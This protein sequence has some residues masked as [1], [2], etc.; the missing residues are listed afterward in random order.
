[1]ARYVKEK[2]VE[3]CFHSCQFF[4]TSGHIMECT[5]PDFEK[6]DWEKKL[7]INQ[8]NS[9]G[10]VPDKCPLRKGATEIVMRIKL[11]DNA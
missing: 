4:S 11:K 10:R 7:I 8:D 6:M 5:H 9:R 1:M 3:Q 2:E